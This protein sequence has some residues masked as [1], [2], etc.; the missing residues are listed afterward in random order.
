VICFYTLFAKEHPYNIC[1]LKVE[2]IE[3]LC[4][5]MARLFC[6]SS[7]DSLTT[8][9]NDNKSPGGNVSPTG[10]Y[11]LVVPLLRCETVDVRDAAVHALG[12]VNSDALK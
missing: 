8:E 3:I 5:Y 12:K 10:L 7:P 11:K 6:S 9:R 2:V 4:N 1:H